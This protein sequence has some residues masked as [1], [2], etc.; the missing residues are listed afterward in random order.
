MVTSSNPATFWRRFVIYHLPVLLY[1]L[2]VLALSSI[3]NLATPQI[4]LIALDK[5]AH[6][7]EF[8]VFAYLTFRSVSNFSPR[9]KLMWIVLLSALFLSLFALLDEIYQHYVPGRHMDVLD[10]VTD[11]GGALIVLVLLGRRYHNAE[12]GRG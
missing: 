10:F 11:M 8:A 12:K 5:V 7:L 6:F 3:P 9:L 2:G 1:S 4:R